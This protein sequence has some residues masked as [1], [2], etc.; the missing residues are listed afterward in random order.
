MLRD[1]RLGCGFLFVGV[2]LAYILGQLGNTPRLGAIFAIVC[3]VIG[4]G[5]FISA[6][7]HH[8]EPASQYGIEGDWQKLDAKFQLYSSKASVKH[9]GE[10]WIVTGCLYARR[11]RALLMLIEDAG[12]LLSSS[13]SFGDR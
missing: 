9:D 1:T 2:P 7:L 6:Y 4:I 5:F 3:G 11:N 13:L 8:D 12:R 10:N